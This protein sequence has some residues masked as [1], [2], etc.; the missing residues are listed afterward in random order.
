MYRVIS[1]RTLVN[2]INWEE[3]VAWVKDWDKGTGSLSYGFDKYGCM[4]SM[5][6]ALDFT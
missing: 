6:D 5:T 2:Q 4:V 1:S 3:S